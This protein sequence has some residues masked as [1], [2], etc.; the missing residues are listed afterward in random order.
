MN[1]DEVQSVLEWLNDGLLG[2]EDTI[3]EL[4]LILISDLAD[5]GD[6]GA[7]EGEGGVVDSI[8]DKLVLD[9]LGELNSGACGEV[10]EMS[11]LSTEEVLDLN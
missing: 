6:S 11:L 2:N 1:S 4:S 10:D 5:L 3:Q 8:E 7:A 9:V